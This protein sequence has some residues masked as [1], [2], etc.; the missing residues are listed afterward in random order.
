MKLFQALTLKFNKPQWAKDTE[1]ALIDTILAENPGLIIMLKDDI[2]KDCKNSEFGRKDTPSVEQIVRAALYKEIKS[3]DYRQLEYHQEDSKI[4]AQFL[5]L[6]EGREYTFQLYQKYIS[7][8]RPESLEKFMVALN[9]IAISEGLESVEKIRMDSTVIETNIHYP[10]NNSLLWDC[11]KESHRLLSAL[12]NEISDIDYRDYLKSA[13]KTYF[14]INVTSKKEQRTRMF[15]SQLETFTKCINQ[16]SNV[17]KKKAIYSQTMLSGNIFNLLER[18]LPIM[19]KIYN[20]T[21][22]HEIERI[23]VDNK[24][25]IFSIHEQH[26]DIIVKGQREV[27]FGHKVDLVSGK[28]NIILLCDVLKGNPKDTANFENNLKNIISTYGETP[29]SVATDGGYASKNNME[30]AKKEGILNIVFN[31]IVGGLKNK[32]SS[33]SMETRLKK[34]RSGME[35]VISNL[36]RGFDLGFCTWKGEVHFKAKV[37]WSVIAYNIRVMAAGMAALMPAQ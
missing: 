33:K 8:I 2:T 35:A 1:L 27:K 5:N 3:L 15:E 14:K 24:D 20:M 16:V 6:D 25:K 17:L 13:K 26:T 31:K 4:C 18:H 7:K 9:K 28:G 12:K 19:E 22:K 23:L 29:K 37:F 10:T 32:F 21:K 30:V 36:K 11:I 34:W